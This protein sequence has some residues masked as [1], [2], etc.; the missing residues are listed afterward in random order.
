[1]FDQQ[2]VDFLFYCLY[3]QF[4][5]CVFWN[6]VGG[7]IGLEGVDVDYCCFFWWYVVCYNVLQGYYQCCIGD[8]WVDGV[9][10]VGVVV[11]V[12]GNCD[13]DGVC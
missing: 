10:G 2:V 11:V 5:Y 3:V 13:F 1:M 7:D 9:F 12:V 6:D 8:D 4:Y